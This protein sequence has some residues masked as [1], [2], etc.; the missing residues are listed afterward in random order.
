MPEIIDDSSLVECSGIF[1]CAKDLEQCNI[2]ISPTPSGKTGYCVPLHCQKNNTCP[3]LGDAC[4]TGSLSGQCKADSTCDYE[5]A[6]ALAMCIT[7]GKNYNG[8]VLLQLK[9]LYIGLFLEPTN[10]NLSTEHTIA[11]VSYT[12]L[13]LPTIYSV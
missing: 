9:Y 5:N 4:T 2:M 13:T 6:I 12:H 7:E 11:T 10:I 1:D 8:C 3:Q